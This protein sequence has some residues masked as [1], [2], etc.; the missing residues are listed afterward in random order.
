MSLPRERHPGTTY[1]V[2]RRC[3]RREMRLRP[4]DAMNAAFA[5][6]LADGCERHGCQLVAVCVM[7][8]H[9]HMVVHDPAGRISDLLRD[10]HATVARF[11]N[12]AHG[13]PGQAFWDG[14]QCD[15]VELG[16][17]DTV[18]EAVAYCLA[19][20]VRAGLVARPEEWP[21]LRTRVADIGTGHGPIFARPSEFFRADGRVSE[22]VQVWTEAPPMVVAA[23]GLEGFKRRVQARLDAIVAAE[24]RA[25][26]TAGRTFM[27]SAA[28]LAQSVW[29]TP[30]APEQR[31]VGADAKPRRTVA[32]RT[33]ARLLALIERV[34]RFR[35]LHRRAIEAF[36]QGF[37]QTV[38]P[39]GTWQA[40]RHYGA[41]RSPGLRLAAA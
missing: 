10:L 8:N 36:A 41:V 40:W 13:V 29:A 7:S 28:V 33:K 14:Q 39:A 35:V 32:A 27:G 24:Q 30:Q 5:V 31:A 6:A 19:N 9:H 3:E 4:C 37:H 23:Y 38:F 2:T 1:L 11:G 26:A 12:A 16:D 22:A 15:A 21:G 18:V 20:P 25:V 17:A 34:Q